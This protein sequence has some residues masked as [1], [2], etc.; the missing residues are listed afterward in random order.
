VD[1]EIRQGSFRGMFIHVF[2]LLTGKGQQQQEG[3]KYSGVFWHMVVDERE[4]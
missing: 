2:S 3:E 1:F 4:R